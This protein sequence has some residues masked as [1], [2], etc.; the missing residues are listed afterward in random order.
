MTIDSLVEN[1]TLGIESFEDAEYV[2]PEEGDDSDIDN[3]MLGW[4][5][6]KVQKLQQLSDL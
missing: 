3:P 1:V 5:H 6:G 4:H 2:E